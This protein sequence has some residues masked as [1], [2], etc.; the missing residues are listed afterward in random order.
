[1]VAV[2]DPPPLRFGLDQ[3]NA[4][5]LGDPLVVGHRQNLKEPQTR[6][7]CNEER[8][9][10]CGEHRKPDASALQTGLLLAGARAGKAHHHVLSLSSS[11]F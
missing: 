4:V 2:E 9:G 8:H 1:V 10:Q 3:A 5:V 7:Q 6:E 11:A